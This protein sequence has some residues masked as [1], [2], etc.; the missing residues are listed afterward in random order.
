MSTT[1]A[2]R[3]PWRA[4]RAALAVLVAV[5]A[6]GA[7]ALGFTLL[8]AGPASAHA[9]LVSTTP[10]D[11]ATLDDAP[12]EVVLEFNEPV[13]SSLGGVRAF[14]I[15]G[16]RIDEGDL[17]VVGTSLRLGLRSD[18]GEGSY[19]VTYRVVSEDG[20]PITG[21]FTFTVGDAE[22]ASDETVAGL[23][24]SEDDRLW[25]VLG[26]VARGLGYVGALGAAG[27]GAFLVLAHDGG[28]EARRLRRW[29]V[30]L[31]CVGIDGVLL[32]I[33]FAAARLTGLGLGAIFEE[34]VLGDVLG[35]GVGPSVAVVLFGLAL[36]MADR[37]NRR[38]A[39]LVG[40]AAAT[41][42]FALAGHTATMEPKALAMVGDAVHVA[43]AAVWFGGLLGLGVVL[44]NRRGEQAASAG[45]VVGRFSAMAAGSLVAV[46]VF[47]VLLG[48]QEVD[49]LEGLT[50][51]T[52]GR[53]LLAKVGVV[54][55]VAAMGAW[56]RFRLV[57][58]MAQAPKAAGE[59]LRSTVRIEAGLLVVAIAVTAALVNTTPADAATG[60]IFSDTVP[61]GEGS[62][63]VVVD[64]NEAGRNVVHLYLYDAGG[65]VVDP[66]FDELT[67]LLTYPADDIGPLEREPVRA[68]TGHH[69]LT[70]IDLLA[71]T[72][73]IEVVGR[74]NQF[75]QVTA[76]VEVPVG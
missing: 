60:G 76:T 58:A 63:N 12:G 10:T 26:G 65:R 52:Y 7:G 40:A 29:L 61:F 11:R 13:S 28:E 50:T 66:E 21:A 44:A 53:L 46:A 20:H 42:G 16:N 56:N 43:A 36:L 41:G 33:P 38:T 31:A 27:L 32:T 4:L 45:S 75:D 69:Q 55:V 19:I 3:R 70:G 49:S 54:G 2:P 1:T 30:I 37:G 18:L 71:G 5:V 34:G 22:A 39:T 68:G 15:D 8:A 35:E 14:D 9:A 59:R 64:P 72:W 48:L 17:D 67:I 51:T 74:L 24:G 73:E 47:G 62:V 23:L 6:A 57:P 25:D